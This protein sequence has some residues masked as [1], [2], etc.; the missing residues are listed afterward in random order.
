MNVVYCLTVLTD[1]LRKGFSVK[2]F[3]VQFVYSL[4]FELSLCDTATIQSNVNF[5]E[6]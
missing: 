1:P 4:H 3:S 6:K 2:S 5:E